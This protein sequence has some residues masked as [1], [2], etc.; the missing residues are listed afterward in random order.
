MEVTTGYMKVT[1]GH[2]KVT[3]GYISESKL[4]Q[5]VLLFTKVTSS[6]AVS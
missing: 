5:P 1:R 2:I 3:G 6:A 4:Y